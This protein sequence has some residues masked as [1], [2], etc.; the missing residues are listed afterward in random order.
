MEYAAL[1][2][3]I[4][5]PFRLAFWSERGCGVFILAAVRDSSGKNTFIAVVIRFLGSVI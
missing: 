1:K 5:E 2:G 4:C 3:V